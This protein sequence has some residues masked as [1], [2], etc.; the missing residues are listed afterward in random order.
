MPGKF[1]LSR[2]SGGQF[3]FNLKA[4][5]NEIILSSET[6][7]A[8]SSAENGIASVRVNAPIDARYERKTST[9]NQPYFVLKAANGETL[10][11]SEMYSSSSAMETGITSAKTNAPT[12]PLVDL[13]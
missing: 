3:K 7:T 4:A 9:A 5:N 10:G 12:A 8:K 13:T 11:R 1:E 6:Y 2:A